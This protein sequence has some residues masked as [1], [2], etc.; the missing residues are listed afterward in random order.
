MVPL[1]RGFPIVGR[2]RILPNVAIPPVLAPAL[3]VFTVNVIA[4]VVREVNEIAKTV[5]ALLPL[6][7]TVGDV[8][9][10]SHSNPAGAVKII[11]PVPIAPFPDSV[12]TGPVK[13]VNAA[14]A[15]SAEIALP[16]VAEVNCAVP[17]LM[18]G[19]VDCWMDGLVMSDAVTVKPPLE[20]K[21]TW[22][23]C[24]PLTSAALSGSVADKS[25]EV[26]PTVSVT[27]L[28]GFQL[29]S[30][31]L[32]VAMKLMP[33]FS[34]VGVPVLPVLVPGAAV[35]PGTSNC[36][37]TNA[38]VLML[39]AGLVFAGI[40][41][42]V[43][44]LAVIV[45]VPAVLSVILKLRV[46]SVSALESG[47]VAFTS[48]EAMATVSFVL[49]TFQF[50]STAF[51]VTV[52]A[53]PAV[54]AVG[55][56]V[57][58]VAVPGAA[59]SPGTNICS[60]AKFAVMTVMAELVLAVLVPS[61]KSLAVTV[62]LPVVFS[63]TLKAFVPPDKAA[64]TGK[65]ALVS[66]EVIATVSR[67]PLTRFQFASTAFTVTLKAVPSFWVFGVPLFPV[68]VPGAAVSPG[69]RSCNCTKRPAFTVII[70]LLLA[71]LVPSVT[72]LAVI[73][74]L[75]AVLRVT[76]KFFVPPARA[77]FAGKAALAS[78]EV[79]EAISV[80]E[81]TTFQFASTAFTVTVKGLPA[82]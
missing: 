38:P 8:E 17:T 72:S 3:A 63:V 6:I 70:P 44:S 46:P 52:K 18:D 33:T 75:P 25:L 10:V 56:P 22:K 26:I 51:T 65:I 47:S 74:A 78:D 31:A 82:A 39:I 12:R 76:L 23:L 53:V 27:P 4:E 43:R 11:V 59:I 37:F 13:L 1:C 79:T 49:T 81:A 62:W 20:L 64:L 80:T 66:D 61:V 54:C 60:F 71:D 24:V 73:V 57:L 48:L 55:A 2:T 14:L 69:A 36:S 77:A 28:K 5:P 50:A 67:T 58:P 42:W 35:S 19:E 40:A 32:T 21:T 29:L 15:V 45:A 7:V 9:V 68:A 41:E 16:P 30:T 34:A